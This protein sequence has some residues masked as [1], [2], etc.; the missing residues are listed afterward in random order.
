MWHLLLPLQFA[1]AYLTSLLKDLKKTPTASVMIV[2]VTSLL[3]TSLQT[4]GV[5]STVDVPWQ[6]PVKTILALTQVLS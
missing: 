4:M 6:E 2:V 3:L 1:T 5:F